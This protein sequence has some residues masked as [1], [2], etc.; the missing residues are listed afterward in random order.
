MDHGTGWVNAF[1]IPRRSA[2]SV[3][4]A[5]RHII[6]NHGKP[7]TVLTDNGEEFLSYQVQNFLRN[8][9][10][11]HIHT[12]PYH[13][14]TNGRLEKFND[15][16]MQMLARCV[17]PDRL[18]QWD[19]Y[20]PDVLLGFRAHW[21]RR[22]GYS[23]FYL[24]YGRDAKLPHDRVYD[25]LIQPPTDHQIQQLQNERL[26][27]IH[28]LDRIRTTVNERAAARLENEAS[29]R[30]EEY[31]ERGI[32]IGD[33]V[34]RRHEGKTKLHPKWDGPFIVYNM[35]SRNTFQLATRGGY[36]LRRLYNGERLRRFR[37][38]WPERN[39]WFAS[40]ALLRHDADVYRHHG[41]RHS[42]RRGGPEPAARNSR[43]A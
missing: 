28:N 3:I 18:N 23:P 19:K 24:A 27:H 34:L 26:E 22:H 43:P 39:L 40:A 41:H 17:S 10:I 1:P 35:T 37:G 9:Y 15:T 12:S 21:N 7:S 25:V 14:Q 32:G 11:R 6:S 36:I 16:I 30:D 33:V 29:Q 13:P 8:L 5:L 2:D 20:V 31:A 42:I 38:P 4:T